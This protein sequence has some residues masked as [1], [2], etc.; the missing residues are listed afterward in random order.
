MMVSFGQANSNNFCM[1]PSASDSN[2]VRCFTTW[3]VSKMHEGQHGRMLASGR[4]N[5]SYQLSGI[6]GCLS[7]SQN[8]CKWPKEP[9]SP[10]NGQWLNSN[11]HKS[12]GRHTL[13]PIIQSSSEN[14]RVV[15]PEAIQ[16]EH[17]PSSLNLVAD[18]K[19]A[20]IKY[21]CNWMIN[22]KIFQIQKALGP[23]Q[24]RRPICITQIDLFASHLTKQLLC[25]YNWR[26]GLEAKVMDAFTQNWAKQFA[27]PTWCR[28]LSVWTK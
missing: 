19:S 15:F 10:E 16:T 13:N 21:Q 28:F 24:I 20:M 1:F 11:I 8:L 9:D 5:P 12:E 4:N 26:L 23:L 6:T 25:Y 3:V 18:S 14:L 22:P 2:R 17:L 7:S 27:N